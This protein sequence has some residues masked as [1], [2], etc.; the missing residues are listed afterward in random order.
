L[1]LH[2]WMQRYKDAWEGREAQKD[3]EVSVARANVVIKAFDSGQLGPKE[4]VRAE[5]ESFNLPGPASGKVP[6]IVYSDGHIIPYQ[7]MSEIQR[8]HF[9]AWASSPKVL[10]VVGT[11]VR[12]AEQ[13][14]L[15]RWATKG[16]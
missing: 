12:D 4:Q 2:L 11:E 7:D 15:E 3:L 8:G 9:N 6:S 14:V 5:I 13:K 1:R 16:R 10:A